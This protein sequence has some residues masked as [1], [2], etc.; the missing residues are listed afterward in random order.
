[1][2]AYVSDA[3]YSLYYLAKS[4]YPGK[5]ILVNVKPRNHLWYT[6]TQAFLEKVSANYAVIPSE[7]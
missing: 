3:P 7:G 2:M 5:Q 6:W 4:L 1:M